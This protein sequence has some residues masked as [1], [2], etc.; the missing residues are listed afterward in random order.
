MTQK[1]TYKT[2]IQ[3]A[4]LK[5]NLS[6]IWI[7]VQRADFPSKYEPLLVAFSALNFP[8]SKNDESKKCSTKY[9]SCKVPDQNLQLILKYV[10]VQ[11]KSTQK[12]VIWKYLLLKQTY[13]TQQK[14]CEFK[15][16]WS[17]P[18]CGVND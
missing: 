17:G 12:L 13:T 1:D 10:Y 2:S 11:Q 7:E 6:E 8:H 16:F 18:F 5:I 4:A 15:I 3:W 9:A 14:N